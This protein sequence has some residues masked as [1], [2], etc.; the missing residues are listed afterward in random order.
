MD[1]VNK[2]KIKNLS[3]AT[4]SQLIE[5]MGE[6]RH[7]KAQILQWLFQKGVDSFSEM[8]NLPLSLR[9][10][11]HDRFTITKLQLVDS[12][13]SAEDTSQKFLLVS[14]DSAT[15][16]AVLM[17]SRGHQTICVSC[18]LGCP[19]GC[20]FCLTGE[21]GFVRNLRSDEI[22]NQILFFK[23]GY[24]R[25]RQRF[26][27]VFMGMGEPLLNID[28]V[29]RALEILNETDAFALREKRITLSTIGFPDKII[30]LSNYHLKFALAISLN[31]TTDSLRKKIMPHA[32]TIHKTLEAAET[33]AEKRGTR[34]SLEYVLL[35]GVNDRPEDAKRLVALT[36][37][38]P[39]KINLIPFNRW[40]GSQFRTPSDERIDRFVQTL[41]PQAPAVT[42]R[43]SQGKDIDAACGL[44][45]VTGGK[46]KQ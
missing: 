39:F 13:R 23:R 18:Q 27:I 43:R 28:N 15:F 3:L 1:A 35:A 17:E 22:L 20:T 26:N 36:A 46:G 40:D 11:L 25:A 10:T 29:S 9:K 8:T 6:K 32:C 44:L 30:A 7:R 42:V 5:E 33:F 41:L 31:A 19:L 2:R 34:V 45:R 14:D 16:E 12:V 24:I 4:I 21:S 37:K 38:R